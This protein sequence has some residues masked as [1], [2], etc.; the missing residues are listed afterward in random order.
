MSFILSF[1][2]YFLSFSPLWLNVLFLDVKSLLEGGNN[3]YTEVISIIF[4]LF[5]E[6]ITMV[7]LFYKFYISNSDIVEKY[8]LS[9]ACE[10]K[11][12]T[13]EFLLSYILP[14]FAFDFTQWDGVFE[15]LVFFAVLWYMCIRH[16]NFSY[17]II[18]ALLSCNIYE[19]IL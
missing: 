5:F 14:L 11:T 19:I 7:C 9:Q 4:I 10:I 1:S 8:E 13:S 16:N 18:L 12:I 6:L 15:F 3:K 2:L 17:N